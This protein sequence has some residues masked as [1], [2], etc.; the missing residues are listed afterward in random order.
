MQ[1]LSWSIIQ[2]QSFKKDLRN[3]WEQTERTV[4]GK[5]RPGSLRK[6]YSLSFQAIKTFFPSKL[7]QGREKN[8][9]K[10][11]V[12]RRSESFSI[13]E[14]LGTN[15]GKIFLSW[16]KQKIFKFFFSFSWELLCHFYW[17]LLGDII[18]VAK[19]LLFHFTSR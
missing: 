1:I 4:E 18:G 11:K 9:F 17:G 2:R 12:E 10:G 3:S 7:S 16:Q 5:R 19:L 13:F 6:I 15:L 14:V 8:I